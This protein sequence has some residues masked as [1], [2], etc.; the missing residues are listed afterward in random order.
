MEN[1]GHAPYMKDSLVT[2]D[3][4]RDSDLDE[5]GDDEEMLLLQMVGSNT[6][7]VSP[8][9]K[10]VLEKDSEPNWTTKQIHPAP[11]VKR[12]RSSSIDLTAFSF[13]RPAPHGRSITFQPTPKRGSTI[14]VPHNN[15][16]V[17]QERHRAFRPLKQ[18]T[19]KW[20]SCVTERPAQEGGRNVSL[21]PTNNKSRVVK[22]R[23]MTG[24]RVISRQSAFAL[25]DSG[26]T[27]LSEEDLFQL[28]IAKMKVREEKDV[29]ASSVRQQMEAN[30]SELTEEN[31]ALRSQLEVVSGEIQ[32]K[33]LE[34][35]EYKSHLEAWKK[36][37]AKFKYIL[38]ELGS[39][40]EALRG[41]ATQLKLTRVSLNKERNDIKDEITEARERLLQSSSVVEKSQSH[42][43][44]SRAMVNSMKQALVNAEEK[45]NSAQERLS[46]EK[47]RSRLLE[48]YIQDNSRLQAKK[49][50]LIRADQLGMLKK[51]DSEFEIVGK[52]VEISQATVQSILRQILEEYHMSFKHMSANSIREKLDIQQ[53]KATVQDCLFQIKSLANA[54]M[55]TSQRSSE[56]NE[57]RTQRLTE[58]LQFVCETLSTNEARC[59]SLHE[60]LE[61][62]VSSIDKLCAFLDVI[63]N[64]ENGLAQQIEHLESRLFEVQIPEKSEPTAAETQE[65][66]ELELKIQQLSAELSRSEEKLLSRTAENEGIRLSLLEAVTKGQEAEARASNL[67]SE[68][69]TLR[70]EVE[71]IETKVREELNR[72]SVIA[73]DQHRAKYEQQ[74]HELLREKV[75]LNKGI[76]KVKHELLKVQ[77]AL[78]VEKENQ[79]QAL[80]RDCIEK[81]ALLAEKDADISRLREMETLTAALKSSVQ[82]QLNDA[83]AK[84]A[85]LE[86]ELTIVKEET[87]ISSQMSQDKLDTFQKDLL[88]KE[89][90]CTRIKKELSTEI[91][92]RLNLE[93]GKSK[94]KSEIHTL[95]RRVQDSE[96]WVKKIKDLLGQMDAISPK[97]LS[98]E[99]WKR[100]MTLLQPAELETL[101]FTTWH[102]PTDGGLSQC[103]NEND[104][105][106]APIVSTPQPSCG[107]SENDVVQTT[108]LIYRTQSFQRGVYSSPIKDD[109]KAGKFEVADRKSP[110]VPETQQSNSIVPFSSIRQL[111]PASCSI[112]EQDHGD[113][114]AML[115]PTPDKEFATEKLGTLSDSNGGSDVAAGTS[116]KHATVKTEDIK[117]QAGELGPLERKNHHLEADQPIGQ[118]TQTTEEKKNVVVTPK[119]VTFETQNPSTSGEKRKAP[120]SENGHDQGSTLQM[121]F[122]GRPVRMSRRTYSRSR[123]I[124]QVRSQE[125]F[126]NQDSFYP[127]SSNTLDRHSAGGMDSVDNKRARVSTSPQ[128]RQQT[129]TNSRF[130]ERKA[131]PT[132]LAS[133]SS[134]YSSLNGSSRP[135]NQRWSARGGRRTRGKNLPA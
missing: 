47:K 10:A 17:N 13:A 133:G 44:E 67:E 105:K 64:R 24:E 32:S 101:D 114:A 37:L 69:T 34:S 77:K 5:I 88:A 50:N 87:C 68:T 48:T 40:Y 19:A 102:E 116:K 35:R 91:S 110:C 22:H 12:P 31:N 122:L 63:Q 23:R 129:R 39:G 132:S 96:H 76:Q 131:S 109:L 62:C 107:V 11:L 28:L 84:V 80:G 94:A 9:L 93:S 106:C 29:A 104:D 98:P 124:S 125:Q 51:L 79:I 112:S 111:S 65:R 97:E 118:D 78:F 55:T 4:E 127:S 119:A 43:L 27:E 38:N 8:N 66:V 25:A 18:C 75:E 41:E 36:K 59:I 121:P 86:K 120:D 3:R 95:L 57:D 42:L 92:A 6:E 15:T 99:T 46:D 134:R 128:R 100:L 72:A 83:N 20:Q 16:Q 53:C 126:A 2:S 103:G 70:A 71:A 117:T 33:I 82:G 7:P 73:R 90:E 85:S 26:S 56:V 81:D 45:T 123:Q 115:V 21:S 61:D 60:R 14:P 130:V 108:E 113:I 135:N 74:I 54:L 1:E 52:Q 89:E 58:Q 30:I 49:I